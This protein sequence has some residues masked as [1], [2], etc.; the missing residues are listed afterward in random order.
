MVSQKR[1]KIVIVNL[2]HPIPHTL[3]ICPRRGNPSKIL[4]DLMKNNN[5]FVLLNSFVDKPIQYWRVVH[6]Q[7]D[8]L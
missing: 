7:M 8:F 3:L 4:D 5:N 6:R 2:S 1:L